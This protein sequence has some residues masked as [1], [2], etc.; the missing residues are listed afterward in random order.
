MTG[1]GRGVLPTSSLSL[2]ILNTKTLP[3][4]HF[5]TPPPLGQGGF[6]RG[7]TPLMIIYIYHGRPLPTPFF[8]VAELT[9]KR[10]NDFNA[11]CFTRGDMKKKKK[12]SF[13]PHGSGGRYNDLRI[14]RYA[15]E[16]PNTVDV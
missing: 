2:P 1:L 12:G 11:F 7:R 13:H 5:Y 6:R 3:C 8:L 9:T 14:S 16:I 10:L 15:T 4:F